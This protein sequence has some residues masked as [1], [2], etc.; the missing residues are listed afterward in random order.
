MKN[1]GTK[2]WNFEHWSRVFDLQLARIWRN[3]IKQF[4][5]PKLIS[6]ERKESII[7]I[8]HLYYKKNKIFS[9]TVSSTLE[10]NILSMLLGSVIKIALYF[11]IIAISTIS[12]ETNS[13]FR[14]SS[15][16][17]NATPTWNNHCMPRQ[18][19][20]PNKINIATFLCM[21]TT[22]IQQI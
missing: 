9:L 22:W 8:F 7:R 21:K 20:S 6:K 19:I 3:I 1:K 15:L 11:L 16:F 5:H 18:Q 14:N 17:K 13:H 4:G 10:M 12:Y 2:L